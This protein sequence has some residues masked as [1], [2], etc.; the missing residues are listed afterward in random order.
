MKVFLMSARA[1]CL[2]LAWFIPRET[3]GQTPTP[4]SITLLK[5]NQPPCTVP[6]VK[7]VIVA[8]VAYQIADSEQS[9]DGFAVS[10]KFQGVNPS[11]TFSVDR[12][13]LDVSSNVNV[14]RRKGVLTLTYP[15]A[16]IMQDERLRRP[17][18]CYFYLHRNTGAGSS[19]VIAL[20]PAIVFR[21]CQ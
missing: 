4:S 1:F 8:R 18:V 2:S 11:M 17:L 9:A 10:I 21:E 3:P 12:M 19:T 7:D 5:L 15:I 16:T 6:S 20:T 13:D 14:T